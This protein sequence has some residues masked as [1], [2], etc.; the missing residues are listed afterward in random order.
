MREKPIIFSGPMVRA[1]LEGHKTQTRRVI[2]CQPESFGPPMWW[3]PDFAQPIRPPSREAYIAEALKRCP[4][5]VGM[6]LWVRETWAEC[7]RIDYPG[8]VL[9]YEGIKYRADGEVRHCSGRTLREWAGKEPQYVGK[10]RPSIF[11]PRWA[12]RITLEVTGVRVGRV[13]DISEEDVLSEG[14]EQVAWESKDY[15][16][17]TC[18]W[19]DCASAIRTRRRAE[20]RKLWDSINAKRGYGWDTNPWVFVYEFRRIA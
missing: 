4:Y 1:I 18:M 19:R 3:L 16:E 15:R 14:T 5:Q 12:S 17:Y 11:M 10:W 6:T 7:G 13:Q 8:V 9:D 20:F 2:P